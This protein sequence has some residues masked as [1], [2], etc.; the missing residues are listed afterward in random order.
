MS[1]DACLV[2]ATCPSSTTRHVSRQTCLTCL[3]GVTSV[4]RVTPATDWL[5]SQHSDVITVPDCVFAFLSH[6][7]FYTICYNNYQGHWDPTVP[8]C[9]GV[10]CQ[11]PKI[12]HGH[13]LQNS[14]RF[15]IMSCVKIYISFDKYSSRH[16]TSPG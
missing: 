15:H 5:A 13:Y 3:T 12:K 4:S 9:V 14:H 16:S 2:T 7:P 1:R 11:L 6:T 10:P 8:L